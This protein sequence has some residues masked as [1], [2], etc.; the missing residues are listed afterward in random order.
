MTHGL[1]FL[2]VHHSRPRP[3][4]T[5][6]PAPPRPRHRLAAVDWLLLGTLLPVCVF[7]V[8]M[9]VIHGV[10]GD[11]VRLPF[12]VSSAPDEQSYP[13]VRRVVST[14]GAE[15]SVIAVGDRV[16]RLEGSDLHG[17]SL[18]ALVLRSYAAPR[19]SRSLSFT[20][21]RGGVSSD[22]RVPLFPGYTYPGCPWWAPLPLL[23][24]YMGNGLLL[25]V[26]GAHWHL[27]RRF[28]VA[29]LLFATTLMPYFQSPTAPRV[30]IARGML[31][32]PL[33]Y[34][35]SLWIICDF[36]PNVRLW[37]PWQRTVAWTLALVLS[38]STIASYWLPDAGLSAILMRSGSAAEIGFQ[39]ALSVA[40]MRVHRRSDALGRRQVKWV[41][42]GFCV[43]T[44]P[45]VIPVAISSFATPPEW[46]GSLFLVAYFVSLAGP[47]GFLVAIV[48]YEFLDIDRLFSATISYSVLAILGIA[49][50]L[51][52]MPT[53]SRA[54]SDAFGLAPANGQILFALGLAAILV[55]AQRFV[56]PRID[57][58]L[59][60]QRVALDQGFANLLTEISSCAD[61]QELTRLVGERLDA[62]LH[63]TAAVV[64]ARAG[65]VFT[66]MAVRGGTAAPAFAA[67]SA[68]IVALQERTTPLAAERWT[69][70]RS[71]SLT[72]FERAAIETLDVAVLVPFRRGPDLVAFSCLGPKRS[73]DIY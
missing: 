65:D 67:Q 71:T 61:T 51:G 33:T 68:L 63:P 59:F 23:L 55:P 13:I 3:P 69:A 4:F 50:V 10:R 42:Y 32:L 27:A 16:L 9:S 54:A 58:L 36:I 60:P 53:A 18:A 38:A 11:F 73:G 8:V 20:F 1:L 64:Y 48:F 41:V 46:I 21:E 39:I 44:L 6:A 56:R 24:C 62:L 45:M 5:R 14:P 40:L 17:L 37:G 47:L 31:L 66:P 12:T 70:R 43:G 35:L 28:Y 2:R 26:R 52:V 25:L 15:P 57:R 22:V 29:S 34:G 49:A 7:G 30:G 72:P 19:I